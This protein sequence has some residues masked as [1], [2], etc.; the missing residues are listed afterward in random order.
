MKNEIVIVITVFWALAAACLIAAERFG[1][2]KY[3]MLLCGAFILSGC[4]SFTTT[5]HPAPVSTVTR[6]ETVYDTE[7][8]TRVRR[9][10]TVDAGGRRYY[11]E[12][13]RTIYVDHYE[14]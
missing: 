11:V 4:L 1:V 6:T 2:A 8:G 3:L 12:G 7:N 5:E 9:V 10:V 13:G 14:Y